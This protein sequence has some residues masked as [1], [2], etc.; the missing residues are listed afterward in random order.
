MK[1]F[2]HKDLE[3]LG[4]IEQDAACGRDARGEKPKKLMER[5]EKFIVSPQAG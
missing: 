1:V 3:N 4:S 5:V 2:K